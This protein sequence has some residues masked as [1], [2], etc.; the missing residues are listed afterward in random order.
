MIRKCVVC[1]KEFEAK[2]PR[3]ITC[4]PECRKKRN[5]DYATKHRMAH[6]SEINAKARK[7]YQDK[8]MKAREVIT[9][10]KRD[11]WK[12]KYFKASRLI[13]I[14]MLGKALMELGIY[15]HYGYLSNIYGNDEWLRYEFKVLS[16]MES[17]VYND[18]EV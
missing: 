3:T 10:V 17:R 9:P 12:D 15:L 6:R 8:K 4:S 11:T 18:H 13:K 5:K 2:A 14:T 7:K 16:E 1:G